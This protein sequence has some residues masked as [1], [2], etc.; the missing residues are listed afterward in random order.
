MG[1]EVKEGQGR[2]KVALFSMPFWPHEASKSLGVRSQRTKTLW[3]IKQCYWGEEPGN[4]NRI[5]SLPFI[6]PVIFSK[7]HHGS[8]SVFSS[9]GITSS[10]YEVMKESLLS[11]L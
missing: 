7:A 4:R 3:L 5:L 2:G 10:S 6:A 11:K 1:S 9:V 8:L